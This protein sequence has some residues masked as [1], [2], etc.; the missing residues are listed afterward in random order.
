MLTISKAL[1]DPEN[2]SHLKKK[3]IMQGWET[4][5]LRNEIFKIYYGTMHHCF[6]YEGKTRAKGKKGVMEKVQRAD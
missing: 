6:S 1:A 3:V 4:V 5:S 2:F